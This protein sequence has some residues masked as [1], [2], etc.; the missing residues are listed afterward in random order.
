[1]RITVVGGGVIG[2]TS[3]LALRRAGHEV[4]VI[5]AETGAAITSAAAGAVWLPFHAAPPERINPWARS[6]YDWLSELARDRPEAG[7]DLLTLYQYVDDERLPWYA[8]AVP[9]LRFTREGLPGREDAP[10]RAAGAWVFEAPRVEPAIFMPW[11]ERELGVP[12]ERRRLKSLDEAPGDLVLNCTGLGAR[13]LTGDRELK[14]IYG[15]IVVVEPGEI[16]LRESIS[17]DR[18]AGALFY[19]IPRRGEVVLGGSS[20]PCADDRPTEISAALVESVLERCRDAGLSP[21]PIVRSYGGLRPF[22]SSVR[23]ERDARTPRVIHNYG[24]GGA[25]YTLCWG[26]AQEVA[27]TVGA[28]A[29]RPEGACP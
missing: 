23:L 3:A 9:E 12:I 20:E 26:C 19:S 7:V 29:R 18:R 4:S 17:D 13:G 8:D 10:R 6:T 2:L 11:I 25:G 28:G 27:A 22:R 14:A 5:A 16:D 21:G 1:M 15:G 24:H